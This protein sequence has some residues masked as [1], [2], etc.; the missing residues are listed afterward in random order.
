MPAESRY[1]AAKSFGF[2][3]ANILIRDPKYATQNI[4]QTASAVEPALYRKVP[5]SM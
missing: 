2:T 5:E 4:L 1:V 3:V